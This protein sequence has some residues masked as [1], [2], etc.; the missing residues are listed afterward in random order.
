[1]SRRVLLVVA[2]LGAG[3]ATSYLCLSRRGYAQ[4][5]RW[6]CVGF[7]YFP[8]RPTNEWRVKHFGCAKLY[9]P[10]N[11]IDRA[12]G[13]GRAPAKEPLWGLSR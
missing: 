12:L 3:Y 7:Y 5:D 10:L 13:T 6:N 9:Y 4:A 2:L 1:M 11:V 8:P